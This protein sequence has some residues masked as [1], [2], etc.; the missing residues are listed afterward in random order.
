MS[1]D[2]KDKPCAGRKRF[3]DK[4]TAQAACYRIAHTDKVKRVPVTCTHCNGWHLS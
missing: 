3:N 2:Q 1:T 4:R